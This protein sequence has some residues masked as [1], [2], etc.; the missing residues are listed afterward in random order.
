MSA[1]TPGPWVLDA[2][3]GDHPTLGHSPELMINGYH[4]IDAGE[5]YSPRGFSVASHMS[6]A[7]ARLIAA[8]PDLHASLNEIYDAAVEQFGYHD[9]RTE[10]AR[11]A[12]AKARGSR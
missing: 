3:Y 5:G 12:L 2:K 11:A 8:A 10:R 9:P 1:H 4:F 7:D 6:E